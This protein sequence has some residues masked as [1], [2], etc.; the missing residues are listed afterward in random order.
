M[1]YYFNNFK[2]DGESLLLTR[3]DE[4]IAIRNNEAKLLA[5]L[6]A[7]PGQ[8]YSKDTILE[9]VWVGK[10]VSDQAV[11]QAVSNL[12]TLFGEDAIKTFPKKG[13]QWQIPLLSGE[14]LG[15]TVHPESASGQQDPRH[16]VRWMLAIVGV[17]CVVLIFLFI[18]KPGSAAEPTTILLA[19]FVLDKESLATTEQLQTVFLEQVSQEGRL[20]VQLLPANDRPDQVVAAPHHFLERHEQST[21]STLLLAGNIRQHEKTLY[22]SFLLQGRSNQWRGYLTAQDAKEL[23]GKLGSLLNKIS[24]INVLWE[25]S[26][27]RLINAQLQILHSENPDDL[28]IHFQLVE[29]LLFLGDNNNAS[30]QA[31]ELERRARAAG[32]IPYESF[33]LMLQA[34]AGYQSMSDEQRI[35]LLDK[36]VALAVSINDAVLQS[37]VMERYTSI[38]YEQHNF[39]ALEHNLLRAFALAES[40]PEQRLQVLRLLSIFSFKLNRADKRDEYL[41]KARAVLDEHKFPAEAYAQLDDI[42]GMYTQ[43][44]QQKEVFF[45]AALNRFKPEQD[46]W[47]KE[48][49][50]RH[51]INLY[52]GQKRWSDALAVLAAEK[53]FSGAELFMRANIYFKQ[54]EIALAQTQAEA[55]FKQANLQG[56]YLASLDSAFL[57]AKIYQQTSQPNLQKNMR[58][59][60]EKNALEPWKKDKYEELERLKLKRPDHF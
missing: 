1:N 34:T 20:A 33:A 45:R 22:L 19:P 49:A 11:F 50:Q 14:L 16:Y 24:S 28:V 44:N 8:V 36:A 26:D 6:L 47:I 51:L 10:V 25:V 42:A 15:V 17:L 39:D 5:F 29:N 43:D 52:V 60:I 21:H 37:R 35:V 13:Y 57:L 46:A 54:N 48:S 59:F 7:N 30:I 12:R 18:R 31:E 55:A 3:N 32:D 4:P 53:N 27:W 2:F 23:A 38:Y 40:S 58:E 56:E 41:A 9:N